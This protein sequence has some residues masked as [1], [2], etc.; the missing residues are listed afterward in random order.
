MHEYAR[1]F[2]ALAA[3]VLT[4][5][6]AD[7]VLSLNRPA[8]ELYGIAATD[9]VGRPLDELFLV[10]GAPWSEH[11]GRA[12]LREHGRWQGTV[13]HATPA[14]KTVAVAWS[15]SR[16]SLPRGEG[17]AHDFDNLLTGIIGNVDLALLD[18]DPA[19]PLAATLREVNKAARSAAALTHQLLAFSRKQMIEPKVLS[20]NDLI[21][22]LD[23]DIHFIGKPYTPQELARK[24]RDV[25]TAQGEPPCK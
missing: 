4:T 22:D 12:A 5:T 10:D 13:R 21:A 24:L 23:D 8:E 3:P 20:L 9:H 1:C 6:V 25:L 2:D 16:M 19:G 17:E 7:V 11:P 14:G 15:L 18:A